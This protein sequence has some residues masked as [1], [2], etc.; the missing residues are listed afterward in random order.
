MDANVFDLVSKLL[1]GKTLPRRFGLY[2]AG[3]YVAIHSGEEITTSASAELHHVLE[4]MGL[5]HGKALLLDYDK[6]EASTMDMHIFMG[7]IY[8]AMHSRQ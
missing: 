3:N 4:Q 1:E 5:S 7:D 2:L 8:W 6:R